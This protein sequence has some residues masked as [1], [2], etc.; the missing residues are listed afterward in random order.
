M[1]KNNH[2]YEIIKKV[3]EEICLAYGTKKGNPPRL[4]LIN[5]P[6][7][8][9]EF[10]GGQEYTIVI[11]EK[12]YELCRQL[13]QDSLN[14]LACILGHELTHF[15]HNHD[16]CLSF[17]RQIGK[18]DISEQ[19]M[20][21]FEKDADVSGLFYA[22]LAGY[23][24]RV[25]PLLVEKIYQEFSIQDSGEY[26]PLLE[27]KKLAQ[28]LLQRVEEIYSVFEAGQLFFAL[29]KYKQAEICFEYLL[30]KDKFPAREVYNNAG[31]AIFMQ[32]LCLV[33]PP[34]F[35]YPLLSDAELRFRN[36]SSIEKQ[37]IKKNIERA[38]KYFETAK[39]LD[40]NYAVAYINLASLYDFTGRYRQAQ[41]ILEELLQNEEV[42][43]KLKE[44]TLTAASIYNIMGIAFAHDSLLKRAEEAFLIAQSLAGN[45]LTIQYNVEY[46]KKFFLINKLTSSS[47]VTQWKE[48][49]RSLYKEE[50]QKLQKYLLQS[51]KKN[52]NFSS[53]NSLLSPQNFA[54][55]EVSDYLTLL[56]PTN[57]QNSTLR[58]LIIEDWSTGNLSKYHFSIQKTHPTPLID[59]CKFKEAVYSVLNIGQSKIAWLNHLN[60]S[61]YLK[62][63]AEYQ[64]YY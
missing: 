43:L 37:E 4:L 34:D 7:I 41:G 16:K 48:K 28:E 30:R 51:L 58:N 59:A 35:Q 39:Q 23:S 12:L 47:E 31:L 11:S 42:N 2:Q 3:Y 25:F 26:P 44:E 63:I 45:N 14:A 60:G 19:S 52:H 36:H 54:K 9:A 27:R 50:D 22:A 1:N 64:V 55:V 13:G 32:V 20:V 53:D 10:R 29:G 49:M 38:R 33:P 18:T 62:Q 24:P 57:N 17:A 46:F 6:H 5:N 8:T 21:I 15:F 61:C 40:P 56:Y